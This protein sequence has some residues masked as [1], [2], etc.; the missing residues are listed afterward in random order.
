MAGNQ[1]RNS[2][3][4]ITNSKSKRNPKKTIK[5][6]GGKVYAIDI[7]R[8]V[9]SMVVAAVVIVAAVNIMAGIFGKREKGDPE[10]IAFAMVSCAENSTFDYTKTYSFIKDIGDGAGYTGGIIGFT[11]M[12][13]D[14]AAVV[15]EYCGRKGRGSELKK[16]ISAL[17]LVVGTDSKNGLG[18]GFV[19]A[20]KKAGKDPAMRKIQN[21][22]RDREFKDPAFKAAERDGLGT[23]GKYIY[24]DTSVQHGPYGEGS[25]MESIRALA[26]KK[27]KL[28][29]EGGREKKYLRAYLDIREKKLLKAIPDLDVSRIS[30]QKKMV[31]DE[32]FE[33]LLPLEF[34]MYGS[35]YTLE[36]DDLI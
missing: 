14:M 27:A 33:M 23:L 20:W 18:K 28:P 4:K 35:D 22:F 16:Y 26:K 29:S 25:S 21:A 24:Y 36:K 3:A 10:K 34:T 6:K 9:I 31:E 12:T 11:T 1:R 17:E 15:K 2:K 13:G 30:A 19:K 7:R 8:M 32:E 5:G